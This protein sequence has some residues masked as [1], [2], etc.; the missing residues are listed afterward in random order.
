MRFANLRRLSRGLRVGVAGVTIPAW[1]CSNHS[2][3][4]SNLEPY[5]D[6]KQRIKSLIISKRQSE[7]IKN[8]KTFIF[9]AHKCMD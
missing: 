1:V 7:G 5:K 8:I 9:M 2:L 4:L 3:A 6:E